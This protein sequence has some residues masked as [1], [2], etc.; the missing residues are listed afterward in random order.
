LRDFDEGYSLAKVAAQKA[1][2]ND[3]AHP[4]AHASLGWI[5]ESYDGDL[6]EAAHYYQRALTLNP[7][8]PNILG[9]SG[10]L[11]RNL[12]RVD[13]A[14]TLLESAVALDPVDP[15]GHSNLG[16]ALLFAGQTEPA[17][18]SMRT[19]VLLSPDYIGAHLL[20]GE[21]L[22]QEGELDAA[23][24]AM[25]QE[26]LEPFRLVGLAMA[27]HALRRTAESE[28]ALAEL[29]DKYEE[30]AA[31]NVAQVFAFRGEAD[32]AFEWLEKAVKFSD[33]GLSEI[34][35][36]PEFSSL[37]SDSRWLPF[38]QSIGRAPEQLAAIKF[39]VNL[40]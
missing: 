5:A 10:L 20:L 30:E 17:I 15:T 19:T 11:V 33:S 26:I 6:A 36:Q 16:H 14:V 21:A 24:E 12:G 2:D 1:L 13:E 40:P 31:Y 18:T 27:Y 34:V 4:E 38:L 35:G 22:I 9:I 25:Q 37:H 39:E 32:K 23:L 3:P 28:T 7:S 29:I 8:D